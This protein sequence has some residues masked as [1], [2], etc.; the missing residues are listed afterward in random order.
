MSTLP[1]PSMKEDEM[2]RTHAVRTMVEFVCASRMHSFSM[3][4]RV[5]L[6]ANT[7]LKVNAYLLRYFLFFVLNACP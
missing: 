5:L 1:H 7:Y 6:G 3:L 2:T 4:C